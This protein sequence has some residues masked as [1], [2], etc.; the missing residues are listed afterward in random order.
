MH[1]AFLAFVLAY[2]VIALQVGPVSAP[3]PPGDLVESLSGDFGGRI[4]DN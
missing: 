1:C 2:K 3:C 4:R